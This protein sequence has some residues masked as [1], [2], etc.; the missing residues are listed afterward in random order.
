[1]T[2]SAG[3]FRLRDHRADIDK[4]ERSRAAA[5]SSEVLQIAAGKIKDKLLGNKI[6]TRDDERGAVSA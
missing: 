5:A 2:T 3:R 1:M 6:L 4:I